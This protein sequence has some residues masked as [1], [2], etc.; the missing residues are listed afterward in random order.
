MEAFA[1]PGLYAPAL[2]PPG[3]QAPAT[4]TVLRFASAGYITAP[5]DDPPHTP[6]PPRILGEIAIG[7]SGADALGLGGRIA[8]GLAEI[9]LWN[10]DRALDGLIDAGL[11]DGRAATV[12]A[13][14]V[15]SAQASDFGS[16]LGAAAP[17]FMG[18]VQRVDPA[19]QQRARLAITD[20]SE[21]LATPLQPVRFDGSGGLEGGESLAGRPKPVCL[22]DVFNVTPVYVGNIDLGDGSLPTYAVHWRAI[23][24]VSAV[25][26]RGVAQASTGSAPTVGQ[27]KAHLASGVIQLGGQ[28]DG[29]VTVDATGDAAYGSTTAAVIRALVQAHGP[30]LG[31][32][33]IDSDAFGFADTDLPGAVGWYRR[34]EEITAASAV[35]EVL[36]GCGAILCGGRAGTL[37]LVDPLA[38][39][40]VQFT[41]PAATILDLAPAPLPAAMRPLPATVAVEWRPNGTPLSDIA[42]SVTDQAVRARLAGPAS[43][44]RTTSSDI[45]LRVQQR[46]ELRLPGRYA[47]E[48]DALARAE[49]WRAFLEAGP[50]AFRITTDRYLGQIEVGDIGRIAYP[51][52]GLQEGARVVV[53]GYREQIAAR[54]LEIEVV[55]VASQGVA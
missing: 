13:L 19:P 23:A 10:A 9:E 48:A 51:A 55:T 45:L 38:A 47:A 31:A 54:R 36:A 40:A 8:L 29:A 32:A 14:P 26:I 16:G 27:Y 4:L 39:G 3:F 50:R 42:G 46:R 53:L 15:L 21:R 41:L 37:R 28:A 24:A 22:G 11:A 1:A 35:D 7:Q 2:L 44:A 17:V 30:A 34:D 12:R 49:R 43:L 5:T 18:V 25:R 20:L 33:Q 6:Y 52:Y